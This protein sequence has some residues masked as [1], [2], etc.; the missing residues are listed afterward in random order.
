MKS[1]GLLVAQR[2]ACSTKPQLPI[3]SAEIE[4]KIGVSRKE[5][6]EK[7]EQ[8]KGKQVVEAKEQKRWEGKKDD[9]DSEDDWEDVG[10][11]CLETMRTRMG[12]RKSTWFEVAP[13]QK[14]HQVERYK[15]ATMTTTRDVETHRHPSLTALSMYAQRV[16]SHDS[17]QTISYR[18]ARTVHEETEVLGNIAL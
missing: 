1:Y 9:G 6:A 15:A 17:C 12:R 11:E 2:L 4:M 14:R 16:P 13:Q 10:S 3:C 18:S 8:D 7:E 5:E